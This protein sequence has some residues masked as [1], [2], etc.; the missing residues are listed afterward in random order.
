MILGQSSKVTKAKIRSHRDY[1]V[2]HN[3]CLWLLQQIRAITLQFDEKRNA[4]ISLMEAL[5]SFLS[6]RQLPGQTAIAYL[7]ELRGWADMIVY[8]GG[9]FVANFELVPEVRTEMQRRAIAHNKKR[10]LAIALI[11]GAGRT[12]Y[13]TLIAHLSN[14]YAMG[15]DQ[16]P[17]VVSAVYSLLT[18]YRTPENT[19]GRSPFQGSQRSAVATDASFA[20]GA[21]FTLHGFVPGSHNKWTK[22]RRRGVLQQ[23]SQLW[24]L[25]L[26]LSAGRHH[27][28]WH[29][30]CTIRLHACPLQRD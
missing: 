10:T 19:M 5:W 27:G 4:Y 26:Q 3:C 28:C 7:Q 30:P 11:T 25:R 17:K 8:H 14:E 6:Y 1:R 24:T 9:T 2:Q 18:D 15:Q 21:T 12:R 13:G 20:S 22:L 23:L 29:Y 16:Y